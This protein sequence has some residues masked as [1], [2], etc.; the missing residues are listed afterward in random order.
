MARKELILA[1]AVVMFSF[2]CQ[3]EAAQISVSWDGLGDGQTWAD[4]NNWNP[5]IVPDNGANTYAVT[6][7]AGAGEV[8]VGLQQW[9]TI[10]RLE[11]YGEI[12]FGSWGGWGSLTLVEPNGLK[13]YGDLCTDEIVIV[14]NITN[15]TGASLRLVDTEITGD[16]N[17]Q[18]G[19]MVIVDLEAWLEDGTL[20]NSGIIIIINPAS[21]LWVEEATLQNTGLISINGGTLM[22]EEIID[23]N[24]TGIIKGFGVICTESSLQTQNNGQIH[25]Y[26]GCLAVASEGGL[27]NDGV[28]GNHP[29]SSLHIKLAE[30]ASNQGTIEVQA[31]G[32]VA[33]DSNLVNEPNATIQ[34]LGG[35]L[36]AT[37]ITQAPDANF[38]GFGQITVA[39]EILIE[40][41]AKIELTGPTN[42]VGDVN[43]PTD[44]TLEIS[45]GTTL[46]TGHTTCNNG[47][48][49][50]IGGRVICQGGLTNNNC[51][52][53][54][55]PG[56]YTNLAD[57]NLDGTVNFKDFADFANTW[58]WKADWYT[59]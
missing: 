2:C 23:N 53:I 32:G 41:S 59:P 26:G 47:T 16:L 50:M 30:D 34:L 29:L 48:I 8:N 19:A 18:A 38:S 54:W 55:E 14:G 39:S 56:T 57:F 28:L 4:A 45:D 33:F 5:N 1:A 6:I 51:N 25:A 37:S 10:D 15:T 21:A 40:S 44:A 43:I 17:N 20:D 7:D 46:I 24:S 3:A 36:A 52:I 9:C 27:I 11:C 42:I 31:G 49:H 22:T 58:L 35:T 12:E 13:N